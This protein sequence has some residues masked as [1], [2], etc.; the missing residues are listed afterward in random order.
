MPSRSGQSAAPD[1]DVVLCL[2]VGG[3]ERARIQEA[4]RGRYAVRFVEHVALL[5]R[6]LGSVDVR[7]GGVIVESHDAQRNSTEAVIRDT[8][9]ARPYIPIVGYCHAGIAHS[10]DIRALAVAGVHE[11]LFHGIDDTRTALR[12]ILAM[13]H[14][15]TVGEVVANA[16]IPLVP[17]RLWPFVK[18]I[19]RHP[20]QSQRVTEVARSLGYHRRTLVNH[21]A[22]ALLPPPQEMIAWCRLAVTGYLLGTTGRTIE[23]I[24]LELDFPSDT[25]LRN[26]VKRHA[27]MRAS[28]VRAAGGLPTIVAAFGRAVERRRSAHQAVG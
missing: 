4:L 9:K 23:S 7:V 27:G 11:L 18:H 19:A 21:C 17:E 8:R 20:A 15:A 3:T 14:Q 26:L 22:Q 16:L 6:L 1:R 5:E 28:E 10:N 24:A 2:V 25:A 12:S 13:A